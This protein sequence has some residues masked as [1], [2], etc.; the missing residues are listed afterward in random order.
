MYSKSYLKLSAEHVDRVVRWNLIVPRR[1]VAWGQSE[2]TEVIVNVERICNEQIVACDLVIHV[3]E[4]WLGWRRLR[5]ITDGE[6][7]PSLMKKKTSVS[8]LNQ[9]ADQ[10]HLKYYLM[11]KMSPEVAWECLISLL[12]ESHG[13]SILCYRKNAVCCHDWLIRPMSNFRRR[14]ICPW[15]FIGPFPKDALGTKIKWLWRISP[16]L[17]RFQKRGLDDLCQ[18]CK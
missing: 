16:S 13:V 18:R 8:H 4:S 11:S 2:K 9:M 12:V 5:G 1:T 6:T 3:H 7:I 10:A 17:Q 15:C 14:I